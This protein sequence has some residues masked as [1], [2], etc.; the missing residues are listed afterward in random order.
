MYSSPKERYQPLTPVGRSMGMAV[1]GIPPG[2]HFIPLP[3]YRGRNLMAKPHQSDHIL[4]K[5][6]SCSRRPVFCRLIDL[7]RVPCRQVVSRLMGLLYSPRNCWAATIVRCTCLALLPVH[8]CLMAILAKLILMSCPPTLRL[9][10]ST[11]L[12]PQLLQAVR[13]QHI[14]PPSRF[15]L[16][17]DAFSYGSQE[18]RNRSTPQLV[19]TWH[20]GRRERQPSHS[21]C[22]KLSTVP[23]PERPQMRPRTTPS[24]SPGTGS[25]VHPP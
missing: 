11:L 24:R 6:F 19:T 1:G 15:R 22:S 4:Y 23:S 17:G 3:P 5:P 13:G 18:T 14:L 12:S 10:G 8:V 21:I 16:C 20:C 7:Q 9:C 25:G 2:P